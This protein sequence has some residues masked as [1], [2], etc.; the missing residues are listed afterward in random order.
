MIKKIIT[1]SDE[2]E[3]LL[4]YAV[5]WIE[6]YNSGRSDNPGEGG[7]DYIPGEYLNVVLKYVKK[8]MMEA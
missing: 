1:V 2:D 6:R 4:K 7:P 5:P 3:K 8:L